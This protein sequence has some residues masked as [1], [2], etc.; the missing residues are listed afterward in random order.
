MARVLKQ[1]MRLF[2]RFDSLRSRSWTAHVE[3]GLHSLSVKKKNYGQSNDYCVEDERKDAQMP[4]PSYRLVLVDLAFSRDLA[5]YQNLKPQS[6]FRS[7]TM[8][9]ELNR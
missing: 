1:D 6:P 9:V 7:C 3:P 2:P 5:V 4:L 8:E